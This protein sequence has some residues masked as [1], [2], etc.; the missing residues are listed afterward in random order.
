MVL[1]R[2]DARSCNAFK[3]HSSSSPDASTNVACGFTNV[4]MCPNAADILTSMRKSELWREK[5]GRASIKCQVTTF[6]IPSEVTTD[7]ETIFYMLLLYH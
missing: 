2:L 4:L 6:E 3:A 7:R 5:S 1:P